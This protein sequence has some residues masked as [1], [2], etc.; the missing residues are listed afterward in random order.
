MIGRILVA[1]VLAMLSTTAFAADLLNYGPEPVMTPVRAFDWTGFH[2]GLVAGYGWDGRGADYSYINIDPPALPF[3]PRGADLNSNG[4][5]FGGV[6]GYDRQTNGVVLGV[7]GDISWTN[8]ADQDTT[9]VPSHPGFNPNLKFKTGDQI[10]W[11]STLRGRIGI[12][13]DRLLVYGTGGL[14]LADVSMKT[15]VMVDE[16]CCLFGSTNDTKV[17]WTAGGGAELAIS[18]HL[19]AKAEVLYFDLGDVSLK[20]TNPLTNI[21]INAEKNVAGV[22]ARGGIGYKF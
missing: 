17:G 21:S 9:L 22:I 2:V 18:D 11:L 6:V 19:T 13:F 1:A 10:N 3:L 14:A 8:F 7:E 20:A 4:A 16:Q 15:S 12:P 5:L